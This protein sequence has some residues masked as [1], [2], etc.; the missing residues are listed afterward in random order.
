MWMRGEMQDAVG[1]RDIKAVYKL[2]QRFGFSQQRIAA[3]TGQSQPEVSAIM[4]GRRVM[5]YEVLIRVADGLGIPRGL[6]G[7]ASCQCP[8]CLAVREP[9]PADDRTSGSSGIRDDG[10]VGCDTDQ[11]AFSTAAGIV[12]VPLLATRPLPSGELRQY[13]GRDHVIGVITMVDLSRSRLPA[14]LGVQRTGLAVLAEVPSMAQVTGADSTSAPF[15]LFV[16]PSATADTAP[17][18]PVGSDRDG[19]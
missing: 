10:W 15:A 7:L 14:S 8:A 4:R 6:A 12:E 3:L 18:A 11:L 9:T 1:R 13:L 2:L 16:T 17:A 5:S 19:T